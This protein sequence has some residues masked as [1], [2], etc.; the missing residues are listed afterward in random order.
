[1]LRSCG[2]GLRRTYQE[3]SS[4][5]LCARLSTDVTLVQDQTG[6]ALGRHVMNVCCLG[7]GLAISLYYSPLLALVAV[8]TVPL[9]T[10]GG[11]VQLAMMSGSNQQGG[12]AGKV[13]LSRALALTPTHHRP[14][15][16]KR[17]EIC[18]I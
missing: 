11:M 4:G 9:M 14:R 1:V 6:G 16:R 7:I 17:R 5:A 12:A 18:S 3:N 15:K 13:T 8:G 10:I 2:A